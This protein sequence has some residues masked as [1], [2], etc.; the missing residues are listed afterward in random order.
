M[1]S[2]YTY[3]GISECANGS[4]RIWAAAVWVDSN[5]YTGTYLA[6]GSPLKPLIRRYAGHSK[7]PKSERLAARIEKKRK[8]WSGYKEITNDVAKYLPEL[9][10][11]IGMHLLVKK[12]KFG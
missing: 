5:G 6:W 9:E 1:I 11:Q 2:N 8:S 4:K 7:M 3:C 12:L 10:S